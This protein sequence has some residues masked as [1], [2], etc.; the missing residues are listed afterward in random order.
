M[1]PLL[2][3][4]HVSKRYARGNIA[5]HQIS[6]DIEPG[7]FVSIIGPSGSGKSTLLR[8]I[9]RLIPVTEGRVLLEGKDLAP[10]H[11]RALREQRQK[12][13]MVFQNYNLV[14]RL[15][16]LQNVLHGRLG[17]LNG[18]RG[19]LGCY[20]EADKLRALELLGQLGLENF[21][22]ARAGELS[23]GQKQRVGI[24][25][26]IMQA[27]QLL[28]ADEPIAS[29]DP[30]SAKTIM[31]ILRDQCRSRNI[32]CLVNLHQLDI[33]R[34]YATRIVA[35]AKGQL[36]FDGPPEQLIAER[37]AHIYAHATP[38]AAPQDSAHAPAP[39][40]SRTR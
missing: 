21:C 3:F 30:A 38:T 36:L 13:G 6:L 8:T 25:R 34:T 35:L 10:L 28:L 40:P 19:L 5:L 17:H 37:V 26:A 39:A 7:E 31:D 15:S 11:G 24:A 33:A 1:A 29:L 4:D 12:I 22:Y 9:N 18:W 14:H 27:P 32:A 23:G 16:V 20:P 2:R